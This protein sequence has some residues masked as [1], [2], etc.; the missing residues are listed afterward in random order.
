MHGPEIYR[1]GAYYPWLNDGGLALRTWNAPV[2]YRFK[3]K[4]P[5][6]GALYVF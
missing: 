4:C 1:Q 5:L 6:A 2:P 3:V